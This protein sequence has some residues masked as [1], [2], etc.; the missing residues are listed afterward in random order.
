[1]CSNVQTHF[2]LPKIVRK[3]SNKLPDNREK[4]N[5]KILLNFFSLEKLPLKPSF[6]FPTMHTNVSHINS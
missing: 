5:F 4:K 3:M 1:M 2:P 6:I